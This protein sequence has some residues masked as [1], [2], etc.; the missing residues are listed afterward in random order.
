MIVFTEL[1]V[2]VKQGEDEGEFLIFLL[3]EESYEAENVVE[4]EWNQH[5]CS[6]LGVIIPYTHTFNSPVQFVDQIDVS[7]SV[8][9]WQY[10][11]ESHDDQD[12][13]HLHCCLWKI[14]YQ[15][16]KTPPVFASITCLD[17]SL[18]IT[19]QENK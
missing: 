3:P 9:C 18:F 7:E 11:V 4:K 8:D 19:I 2:D 1:W 5:R 16:R 15:V 14:K 12:C 10:D 13:I 17:E 6:H